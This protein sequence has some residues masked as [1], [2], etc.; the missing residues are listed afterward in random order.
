[1]HP[2]VLRETDAEDGCPVC[3]MPLEQIPPA[4]STAMAEGGSAVGGDSTGYLCPM[5]C[6]EEKT[7]PEPG[8]CPVCNMALERSE[9]L[10]IEGLLAVP[11]SAVLDSGTRT[12][13]YVERSRGLFEPRE[14]IASPRASDYV[15]VLRGL[16]DGE[17]IA[18]RGGFLIDSQFQITGHPS[19]F[20]PGGL[21]AD[22]SHA[23]RPPEPI[24]EPIP[25]LNPEPVRPSEGDQRSPPPPENHQ[26]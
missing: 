8:R 23:H 6:E 5:R 25:E 24:P 16:S 2:Q 3:G 26:H 20:Y 21:H 13:V 12:I 1:M 9:E 14:V 19:L 17:R 18:V 15:P 22:M 4:A 10:V 7:Y 11:V